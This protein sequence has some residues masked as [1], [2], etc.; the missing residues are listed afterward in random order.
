ML[1]RLPAD[2]DRPKAARVH[3]LTEN[4][5]WSAA[6]QLPILGPVID[7]DMENM[8]LVQRGLKASPNGKVHLAR[9]V[10]A[11]IR[12]FHQTLDLYLS[13]HPRG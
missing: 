5:P 6:K 1:K 7:Q 13:T 3:W 4:E 10:E 9:Y 2:G 8:P 12:H 11:R